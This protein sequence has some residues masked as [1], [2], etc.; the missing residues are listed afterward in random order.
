[1]R[2]NEFAKI[3]SATDYCGPEPA[4]GIQYS[5]F[6]KKIEKWCSNAHYKY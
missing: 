3:G 5:I 4:I 6:I 2:E 1:M